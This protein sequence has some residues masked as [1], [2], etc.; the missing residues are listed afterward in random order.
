[1]TALADQFA[2]LIGALQGRGSGNAFQGIEGAVYESS[3][4]K[5]TWHDFLGKVNAVQTFA[6][7]SLRRFIGPAA[8]AHGL[9]RDAERGADF[10]AVGGAR[11]ARLSRRSDR[12]RAACSLRAR[13]NPR[14]HGEPIARQP[15]VG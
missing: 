15:A 13:G 14:Q 4:V 12:R 6:A 8:L 2:R 10:P 1:M 3:R 5:S 11:S 9:L 7:G